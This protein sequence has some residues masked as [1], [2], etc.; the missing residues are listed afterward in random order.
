[1]EVCWFY[2]RSLLAEVPYS[3]LRWFAFWAAGWQLTVTWYRKRI[4]NILDHML[5]LVRRIKPANIQAADRYFAG[6]GIQRVELLLRA[7]RPTEPGDSYQNNMQLE[8]LA[9]EFHKLEAAKLKSQLQ[10][11]RYKLDNVD[12]LRLVTGAQSSGLRR[13]EVVSDL[14]YCRCAY[15]MLI[16]TA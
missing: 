7:T 13:I 4:Y 6:E 3:L 15:A 1:L 11:L 2:S 10:E 14:L 9:R 16:Y 12:T 8:D 5:Q